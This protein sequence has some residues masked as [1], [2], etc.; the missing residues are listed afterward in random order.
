MYEYTGSSKKLIASS[1][2][3]PGVLITFA[4]LR[5]KISSIKN[6]DQLNS[7]LLH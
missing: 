4:P 5:D 1:K 6:N 7:T 3:F 2:D